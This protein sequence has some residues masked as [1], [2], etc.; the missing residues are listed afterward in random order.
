MSPHKTVL[1]RGLHPHTFL[2]RSAVC[3]WHFPSPVVHYLSRRRLASDTRSRKRIRASR[4]VT[5]GVNGPAMTNGFSAEGAVGPRRHRRRERGP[6]ILPSPGPEPK[7]EGCLFRRSGGPCPADEHCQPGQELPWIPRLLLS[8]LPAQ[9]HI[10]PSRRGGAGG[11]GDG[12]PP[13]NPAPPAPPG[14]CPQSY[15]HP[16]P[17]TA[18]RIPILC[19]ESPVL[20][21]RPRTQ[22][23]LGRHQRIPTVSVTENSTNLF[24]RG[25]GGQSPGSAPRDLHQDAGRVCLPAPPPAAPRGSRGKH[26]LLLP[27]SGDCQHTLARGHTLQHLPNS[28]SS[29]H[30]SSCVTS[31]SLWPRD[32]GLSRTAHPENL[33]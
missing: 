6:E 5:R 29:H 31:P 32:S 10:G 22:R 12:S 33:G 11:Q 26:S 4:R 27:T 16:V 14:V 9:A 8:G 23:L 21:R 18:S 25:S 24:S 20:E 19:K 15:P 2:T 7:L 1:G 17:H 28:L 3:S 13:W 30:S